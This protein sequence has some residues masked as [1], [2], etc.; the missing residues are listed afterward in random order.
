MTVQ[1]KQPKIPAEAPIFELA[2]FIG[3]TFSIECKRNAKGWSAPPT[4]S[5]PAGVNYTAL[6]N[7]DCKLPERD[8]TMSVKFIITEDLKNLNITCYDAWTDRYSDSLLVITETKCEYK[9]IN[10]HSSIL[11]H[12]NMAAMHQ[13]GL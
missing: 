9:L 10:I 2:L 3:D 11:L 7:K 4:T 5:P 6:T 13:P 8:N 1:C 12:C